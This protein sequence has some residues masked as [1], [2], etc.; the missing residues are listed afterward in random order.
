MTILKK[1]YN[2]LSF[3]PSEYEV[4]ESHINAINK[5]NPEWID[6]YKTIV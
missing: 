4:P 2:L 5:M 3:R 1:L 6:L